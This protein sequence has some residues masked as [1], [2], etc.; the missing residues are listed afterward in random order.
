MIE[1]W[2]PV[3]GFEGLYE[4]SD[5]GRV[6]SFPTRTWPGRR[7]LRPSHHV[8]GGYLFVNLRHDG[9][10][11]HRKVHHL[12]CEAFNG[13]RPEGTMTRHLDG[14]HLNNTPANLA[15]GTGSENQYDKVRHGRHH[16]AI[17]TECKNGHPL[18]GANLYINATSGARQCRTCQHKT[19]RAWAVAHKPERTTQ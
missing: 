19:K 11:Y 6:A 8:R 15:W 5:L 3:V 16:N 1:K 2:R 17:K 4:V 13:P 18:S 10:S 14:D 7:I 9:R 12:V